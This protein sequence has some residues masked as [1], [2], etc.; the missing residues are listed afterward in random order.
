M[1]N[2]QPLQIV[3]IGFPDRESWTGSDAQITG[4]EY[5][6]VQL[7]HHFLNTH[8]ASRLPWP[9][10]SVQD[11]SQH[12]KD[13]DTASTL[14]NTN[15][16]F[17]E[18]RP[19]SSTGRKILSIV[20]PNAPQMAIRGDCATPVAPSKTARSRGNP[21]W[22]RAH[23][24]EEATRK[25]MP[26]QFPKRRGNPGLQLQMLHRRLFPGPRQSPGSS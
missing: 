4:P 26:S 20:P 14:M 19:P 24:R 16:P 6:C 11:D 23:H 18:A 12:A 2:F 1:G 9:R 10:R 25:R 13:S 8:R 21:Y 3:E 7:P 5:P 22:P 15:S 17:S